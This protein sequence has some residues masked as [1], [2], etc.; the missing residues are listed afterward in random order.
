VSDLNED[1]PHHYEVRLT[2]PAEVDVEAERAR[3]AGIV[4]EEYA[5][6]WQDGLLAEIQQLELF[7]AS[8]PVARENDLYNVEVRRSLYYGPSRR[9]RSSGAVYRILFHIIEP[10]EDEP[11]GIVRVLHI[12]HGARRPLT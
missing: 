10:S 7:P 4:S 6:R 1:E 5:D 9:R 11:V 3:L 2:E 8:H 12:W